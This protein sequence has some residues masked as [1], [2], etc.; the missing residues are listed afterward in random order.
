M[1]KKITKQKEKIAK[2]E[3]KE[4]EAAE[5]LNSISSELKGEKDTLS[6]L[7][8]DYIY[9]LMQ[10]GQISFESTIE[11]LNQAQLEDEEVY[12]EQEEAGEAFEET[13]SADEDTDEEPEDKQEIKKSFW[14]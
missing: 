9:Q 3:A 2:L 4:A 12:K 14:Q 1:L 5:K 6:N 10:D 11:L 13:E 8:K 7:E